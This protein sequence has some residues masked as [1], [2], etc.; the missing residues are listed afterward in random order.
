MS[1]T[2]VNLRHLFVVGII[3][4]F[5]DFPPSLQEIFDEACDK[6]ATGQSGR[7]M[8]N[9]IQSAAAAGRGRLTNE[10]DC[11][12]PADEMGRPCMRMTESARNGNTGCLRMRLLREVEGQHEQFS[13]RVLDFDTAPF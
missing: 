13:S 9:E 4:S 10:C 5:V 6:G 11:V 12:G 7:M 3:A 8:R 1:L 2:S